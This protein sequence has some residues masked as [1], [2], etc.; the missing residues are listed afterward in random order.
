[1]T[2]SVE[3]TREAAEDL[4]AIGEYYYSHA[5]ANVAE[6][7]LTEIESAIASLSAQPERGHL[8][9]ELYSIRNAKEREII[10]GRYR[11]LYQIKHRSVY[12]IAIFDGRQN[13]KTHLL[14]R[15]TR[16]R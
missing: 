16:L 8:P 13:V 12:V 6:Q 15:R 7:I 14:N 10:A 1:M 4:L 5:G 2:F 11:I 9:H 3:L